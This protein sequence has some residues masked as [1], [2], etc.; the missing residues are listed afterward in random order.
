[1]SLEDALKKAKERIL[2]PGFYYKLLKR[3][4]EEFPEE[5]ILIIFYSNI[6]NEPRKVIE[7][8]LDFLEVDP[9]F[10]PEYLDRKVAPTKFKSTVPGKLFHSISSFLKRSTLGKKI[11]KSDFVR[12]C[13]YKFQD[14]YTKDKDRTPMN[15]E[16]RKLLKKIYKED[17][18][19][20]EDLINKDLSHWK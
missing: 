15:P 9:S 10:E 20:L 7:K 6:K 2:G 5:N 18:E 13:C 3:Y 17:I 8:T 14:F 4:Y 12:R 19:K 16:T 11:A 1:R